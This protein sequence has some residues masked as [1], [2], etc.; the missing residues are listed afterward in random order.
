MKSSKYNITETNL[1]DKDYNE[2]QNVSQNDKNLNQRSKK[3][4]SE[5]QC[6]NVNTSE[7]ILINNAYDVYSYDKNIFDVHNA[8]TNANQCPEQSIELVCNC[9]T[10]DVFGSA[11]SRLKQQQQ[12][13]QQ[14]CSEHNVISSSRSCCSTPKL[15]DNSFSQHSLDRR[16]AKANRQTSIPGAKHTYIYK[17]SSSGSKKN[18]S[19]T[20]IQS[21]EVINTHLEPNKF[22][23]DSYREENCTIKPY[24]YDKDLKCDDYGFRR[25]FSRSCQRL[26]QRNVSDLK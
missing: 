1:N 8:E 11:K 25:D 7:E 24:C 14:K 17:K 18:L 3:T 2:Y 26:V 13:Q 20:K 5:R 16:F 6:Q 9:A 22:L 4:Q 21:P 23:Y 12:Q 19:Q 10:N 15:E